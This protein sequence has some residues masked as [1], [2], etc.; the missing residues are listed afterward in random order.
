[1][2][3]D[4]WWDHMNDVMD[5]RHMD[6]ASWWPLW[7]VLLVLVVGAVVALVALSTRPRTTH[8]TGSQAPPTGHVPQG[9]RPRRGAAARA[10]RAR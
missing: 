7:W 9:R 6:G 1:M 10:V 5:G 8:P 2:G 3:D 4:R